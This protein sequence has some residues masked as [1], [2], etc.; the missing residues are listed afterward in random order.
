MDYPTPSQLNGTF[1]S[2]WG[3]V[4]IPV[5][6]K[7][8]GNISLV[9][10]D[11]ANASSALSGGLAI[12]LL[13]L[14]IKN[15]RVDIAKEKLCEMAIKNNC[16]FIFLL[17]DDTIPPSDTLIKMIKLWKSGDQYKVISGVYWS[18]S[19]PSVPLVFKGNLEGSFYDWKTTDLI[20]ADAAGA[21]MLFI[22]LEM[23]KKL[24]KPWFSCS[25]YFE[26]PRGGLDMKMWELQ[27]MIGGE[28][29]KGKKA[30]KKVIAQLEKQ[31]LDLGD[32]IEG[33]KNGNYPPE[34]LLNSNADGSA[35]EDL[36]F[37]K[38]IKENG[39]Q[40]WVDCSIQA[41][42]QDKKTGKLF[43]LTPD[44]PQSRPRYEGKNKPGDAIILDIGA[45]DYTGYLKEG[46][47][48]RVD[49]D[50]TMNPDVLADARFLPFKD[51]FADAIFSS[52]ALEHISFRETMATLK[53]WGRV[54]KPGG[55]MVIV[56]P[57][58]K[59]AA[60]Q[61]LAPK[62]AQDTAERAMFFFTSAQKGDL[63]S[64]T[65]DVHR[66][67]F[68]PQSIKGVLERT[69]VFG[70]IEVYTSE[71]NFDNWDED[72]MIA[73]DD[74]GYNIVVI[75]KKVKQ[76]IPISLQLPIKDQE[77]MAQKL[78][79]AKEVVIKRPKASRGIVEVQKPKVKV[80]KVT[81]VVK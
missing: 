29:K 74:M 33:A 17:D 24:P 67:G 6:D 3:A 45:G 48:I 54:L 26:D 44:M 10:H 57:N 46:T 40:L 18:K 73:K 63:R 52:H 4:G 80:T 11:W 32:Q 77:E 68:T 7:G 1:R 25:Y 70:D 34:I 15:Y 14:Q 75:A 2:Y 64:A 27:E 39:V 13:R 22:D 78:P 19:E 42:H 41:W 51:C 21:G 12:T 8:D 49:I 16:Q 31:M 72:G 37:F 35:T 20:K 30:D 71:G 81:K 56:I 58:L 5:L 65:Q 47:P 61:I 50:P 43:G 60:K 28:L 76:I 9:T 66:A 53:E 55:R 69:K 62:I 23:L 38:K 79:Q 59:W 36:Y